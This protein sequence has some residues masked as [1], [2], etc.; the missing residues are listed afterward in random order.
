MTPGSFFKG[1]QTCKYSD[2]MKNFIV[3]LLA[4]L[5]STSLLAKTPNKY[6]KETSKL[7]TDT[8]LLPPKLFINCAG[9]RCYYDYLR[10]DLTF[11]DFVRDR[12]VCDI[13]ALVTDLTTGSGGKQYTVSLY[14]HNHF[15]GMADTLRFAT[16]KTDTDDN[17]RKQLARTFRRGLARFLIHSVYI[18]QVE[19]SLPTRDRQSSDSIQKAKDSWNFWVFSIS[20][21]GTARGESNK[22]YL[23][24]SAD[25]RA[26]R[27]TPHSKFISHLYYNDNRNHYTVDGESIRVQTVDYGLSSYYV[28][29]I[30]THWSMGGFYR[31]YHSIYQNIGLSQQVAPALEFSFFPVTEVT[32]R[33]FRWIYQVGV[34]SLRY[35]EPT[36][37]DKTQETL[38]FHQLTG[39]YGVIQPWGTLSAHLTAYQ[40]LHDLSKNRLSLNLE[41]SW[42]IVRGLSFQINANASLINNQISLAR[43]AIATDAALLNGRQL[44]TNFNYYTSMGLS[45]TFGSINNSVVNPRFSNVD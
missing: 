22:Q 19:V 40:Y 24:L 15:K 43:S 13:E 9:A 28:R 44:P 3:L 26:N 14:G 2:V 32:R 21:D 17:V 4:G 42:R 16:R 31:A 10:T 33:Q 41:V 39:I 27:I 20:G 29:S 34:R 18:D 35:L 7:Q 23:S 38:P 6:G 8:L 25:V 37:Y 30:S 12:F 5:C 1:S 36:V 45:Y 11:F